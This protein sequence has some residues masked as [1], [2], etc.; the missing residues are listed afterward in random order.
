MFYLFNAL[1][2][3]NSKG[4]GKDQ[5]QKS[6]ETCEGI[7]ERIIYPTQHTCT[8]TLAPTH[9]PL[10]TTTA[11]TTLSCNKQTIFTQHSNPL[12]YYTN[13][14]KQ[15]SNTSRNIVAIRTPYSNTF[16][17]SM[18]Q[19]TSQYT[20]TQHTTTFTQSSNTS[21]NIVISNSHTGTVQQHFRTLDHTTHISVHIHTTHQHFMQH[22]H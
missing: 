6:K 8:R 9:A 10:H 5:D 4:F 13:T 17:H 21:C 19:H 2:K 15:S 3:K 12:T 22:G 1:N 7:K 11:H 16:A 20:F 14:F 18:I